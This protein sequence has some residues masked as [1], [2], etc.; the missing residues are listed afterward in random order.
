VRRGLWKIDLMETDN[1]LN[2][3]SVE[4]SLCKLVLMI[5]KLRALFHINGE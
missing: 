2:T 3:G 5:A 1:L 4:G